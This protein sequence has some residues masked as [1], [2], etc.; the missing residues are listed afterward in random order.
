VNWLQ[1]IYSMLGCRPEVCGFRGSF[2]ASSSTDSVHCQYE[3]AHLAQT[4]SALC[5]LLILGDDL[6]RVD[7][8]AILNAVKLCQL[9]DG[10]FAGAGIDSENDM[11]FVFCAISICYILNDFSF[12]NVEKMCE[13]VKRSYGYDGG[14]AQGP[15]LESHGKKKRFINQGCTS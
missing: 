10:S 7:R 1:Q 5:C 3:S 15:C 9:E 2:S 14:I 13:F 4:Y 11:R 8:V 6:A 12:I